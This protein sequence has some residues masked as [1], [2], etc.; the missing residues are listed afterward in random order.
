MAIW[1]YKINFYL[2][3]MY[4]LS[5]LTTAKQIRQDLCKVA[6]RLAMAR[7][8]E[9]GE[10]TPDEALEKQEEAI[11]NIDAYGLTLEDEPSFWAIFGMNK[12]EVQPIFS[13][14][15]I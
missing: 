2:F 15:I 1:G 3:F 9:N 14:S 13:G 8:V 10:I 11:S 6:Y 5:F 4:T 12:R 7:L